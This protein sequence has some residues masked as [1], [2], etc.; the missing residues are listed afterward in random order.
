MNVLCQRINLVQSLVFEGE[1]LLRY[2]FFVDHIDL[3]F[4]V[5]LVTEN[6]SQNRLE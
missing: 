2:V 4:T 1:L 6:G 3:T 5:A